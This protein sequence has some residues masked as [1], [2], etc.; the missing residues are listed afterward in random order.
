MQLFARYNSRRLATAGMAAGAALLVVGGL[1]GWQEYE[2]QSLRS[3]WAAMQA[4]V[5]ALE[6]VQNRIRDYRPWYDSGFRTLTI[7]KRVSECFPDSGAV[8]AKSFELQGA[9]VV[10][11]S[12][13]ARDNAALLRT[14]DELRKTK[15]VQGLKIEQIRGKAP[16]AQFTFTFRWNQNPGS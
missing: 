1:F 4:E 2:R 3:E 8:T 16:A 10:T 11:V 13:T 6:T 14:I 7:L 12:G 5:A 15:Q 9:N